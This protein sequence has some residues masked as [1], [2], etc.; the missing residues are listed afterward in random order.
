[1]WAHM[2]YVFLLTESN[3][4][5]RRMSKKVKELVRSIHIVVG[6]LY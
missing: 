6:Y 3:D 1:M 2:V 5:F 4:G